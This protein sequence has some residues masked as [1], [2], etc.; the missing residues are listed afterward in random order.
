MNT[1][2]H[3]TK[4][5]SPRLTMLLNHL[6]EEVNELKAGS[7]DIESKIASI[8]HTVRPSQANNET[9]NPNCALDELHNLILEIQ[10]VNGCLR[11]HINTLNEVV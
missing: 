2:P 7:D 11:S 4:Q 9:E 6:R 8:H 5:E 10:E 3:S 1:E